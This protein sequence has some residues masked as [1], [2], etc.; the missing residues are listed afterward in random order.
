MNTSET[1]STT[2]STNAELSRVEDACRVIKNIKPIANNDERKLLLG[3]LAAAHKSLVVSF[4]NAH[5]FNL[6]WNSPSFAKTLYLSDVLLKDGVGISLFTKA[7][8]INSGINMN[9]TD[10]IPEITAAFAGRRVAV[11]GTKEPYLS[12]A[13][14]KI[15][16]LGAEVVLTLDG[17]QPS[18]LYVS[19]LKECAADLVILG[20]GMP[21]Q[22]EV[23]MLIA[24]H[25]TTPVVIINGGAILDFWA[26]RFPRAPRIWQKMRLE[27]L[28]RMLL[29]PRRLWKRYI[30]GGFA[31]AIHLLQLRLS[32][33]L[34]Q[35]T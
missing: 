12:L 6:A 33:Q 16:A 25:A 20:M 29:E 4:V 28:F 19:S 8:G 18:T 13:V 1:L 21:K 26:N 2:R 7:L 14:S 9:G 35:N 24:E 30:L 34:S 31:F 27:W 11:F 22:E 23:S 5:A 3:S 32:R 15:K 17:F 10:F